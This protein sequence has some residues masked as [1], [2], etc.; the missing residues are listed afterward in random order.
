MHNANCRLLLSDHKDHKFLR[1]DLNLLEEKIIL[2]YFFPLD[3]TEVGN[4]YRPIP[5]QQSSKN[6]CS[7]T[8]F[9][10]KNVFVKV[11]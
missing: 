1:V 8:F 5:T 11:S 7:K 4:I 9:H 2:F 3:V 10:Q 6:D